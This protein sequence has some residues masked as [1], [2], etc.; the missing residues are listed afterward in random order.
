MVR[1]GNIDF[2]EVLGKPVHHLTV[3]IL[4]RCHGKIGPLVRIR[5]VIV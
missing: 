2:G 4:D 5:V 1:S 3:L